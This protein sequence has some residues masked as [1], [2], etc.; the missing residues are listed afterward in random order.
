MYTIIRRR[1]DEAGRS[2]SPPLDIGNRENATE[3]NSGYESLSSHQP[4]ETAT[5]ATIAPTEI[6]HPPTHDQTEHIYD[7]MVPRDL[8]TTPVSGTVPGVYYNV[9]PAD[10]ASSSGNTYQSLQPSQAAAVAYAQL[11][12]D[13]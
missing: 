1:R 13:G 12:F 8:H 11:Q 3:I 4:S 9:M 7:D 2:Q 6:S 10:T 5:Y